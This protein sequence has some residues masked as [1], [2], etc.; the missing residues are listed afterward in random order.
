MSLGVPHIDASDFYGPHVAN[1]LIRRALYSYPENLTI[2][3]RV[4]A[5]RTSDAYTRGGL[6]CMW[7]VMTS[8]ARR[9]AWPAEARHISSANIRSSTASRLNATS[10]GSGA[11]LMF[12]L[13]EASLTITLNSEGE[14]FEILIDGGIYRSSLSNKNMVG[15]VDGMLEDDLSLYAANEK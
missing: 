2:A 1:E 13:E 11:A 7:K 15:F 12:I 5:R 4:G 14:T 9:T 6:W 3:T 10:S 8:R